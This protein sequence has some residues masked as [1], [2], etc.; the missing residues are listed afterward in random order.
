[1]RSTIKLLGATSL[2]VG[3][4]VGAGIY[5]L[6]VSLASFGILSVVGWVVTTFGALALALTF[7]RLVRN[8]P[9]VGGPYAYARKAFGN[10]AGFQ[11][12]WGYWTSCLISNAALSVACVSYLSVFIEEISQ[13]RIASC[14]T[15]IGL[16][17]LATA[18]NAWGIRRASF[19][20]VLLTILK[21]SP[22]LLVGVGGLFFFDSANLAP[23][24]EHRSHVFASVNQAMLLTLFAFLGLESATI[25]AHQVEN[26]AET[27][28]RATVLGTVIS[29]ILYVMVTISVIGLVGQTALAQSKAPIADAAHILLGAGA[30]PI[31]AIG[32]LISAFGCLLGLVMLQ[33]QMPYAMAL[34]GLMPRAFARLSVHDVPVFGTAVSSVL[35]SIMLFMNY[36]DSLANQFTALVTLSTFIMLLPYGFCVVADILSRFKQTR[37]R[38]AN[39][40]FSLTLP[41][42][43]L[44]FT[45]WLLFNS[46]MESTLLGV[47][48]FGIGFIVYRAFI[49]RGLQRPAQPTAGETP[50]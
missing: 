40:Y 46:G 49:R 27:I 3:N 24:V 44:A 38:D 23:A 15:A 10:L 7:C 28:P 17:W 21:L 30:A 45:I 29:S 11:M 36:V 4:M 42:F 37:S 19:F 48:F 32:A 8:N 5:F 12:A 47:G 39:F 18:I 6:P 22:L 14:G 9:E 43:A 41:M 50:S 25:P 13:N 33:G 2:V 34:D 31:A 26:P 1:M 16:I 20:Q 35:I